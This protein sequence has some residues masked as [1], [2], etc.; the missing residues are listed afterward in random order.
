ML[1]TSMIFFRI[2]GSAGCPGLMDSSAAR[3]ARIAR[4]NG[5]AL[6]SKRVRQFEGCSFQYGLD[7]PQR[8]AEKLERHDLFQAF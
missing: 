6:H 5:F 1:T 2:A 8:K 3:I 4:V 7:L